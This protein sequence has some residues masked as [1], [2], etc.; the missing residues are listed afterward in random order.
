MPIFLSSVSAISHFH[1]FVP[2]F[3][4]SRTFMPITLLRVYATAYNCLKLAIALPV[5]VV[6]LDPSVVVR[7]QPQALLDTAKVN[8]QEETLD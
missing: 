1:F 8:H 7:E 3:T 6:K 5:P 2:G 4:S